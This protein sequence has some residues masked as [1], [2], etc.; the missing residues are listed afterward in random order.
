MR[1]TLLLAVV[2]ATSAA[3][4]VMLGIVAAGWTPRVEYVLAVAFVVVVVLASL[5]RLSRVLA[6]PSWPGPRSMPMEPGGVDPRLGA[7]ETALH[8]STEAVG[9]CR[10]RVQ[11][12]LVELAIHRLGRHRD[13]GLV[14]DPDA[15]RDLLGDEAFQFL[16]TVIEEPPTAAT[17][18]HTVEAI[19][20]L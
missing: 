16:T 10:R 20:R 7:I 1:R 19:E 6:D 3:S 5:R 17:L 9:T 13:V 15:A 18:T 12:L 11:P 2:L 14:E 4:I 8:R